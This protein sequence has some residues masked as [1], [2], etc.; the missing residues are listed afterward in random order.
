MLRAR[1]ACI[2]SSD[3]ALAARGINRGQFA[4]AQQQHARTQPTVTADPVPYSGGIGLEHQFGG[5]RLSIHTALLVDRARGV[6]S[7][8]R[9]ARHAD[10]VAR[11]HVEHQRASRDAR[12]IDNDALTG[13][14][15][16]LALLKEW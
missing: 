4:S 10:A 7:Q 3:G 15:H 2:R 5:L 9:A 1:S 16:A 13:G 11:H 6:K 14:A 8:D 12:S